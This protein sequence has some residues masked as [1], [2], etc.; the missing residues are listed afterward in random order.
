MKKNEQMFFSGRVDSFAN[1][2]AQWYFSDACVI[3]STSISAFST[4]LSEIFDLSQPMQ[5]IR[6]PLKVISPILHSTRPDNGTDH[7]T[8]AG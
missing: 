7:I 3:L 1:H 5:E 2:G 6:S 8:R 4:Y